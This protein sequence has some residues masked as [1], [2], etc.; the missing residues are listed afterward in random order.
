[1]SL[2]HIAMSVA[3][4]DQSRDFYI[5]A[6]SPLGYKV[7]MTQRDGEVTS[8]PAAKPREKTGPLHIAFGASNRAQVRKFHEAAI[9][10]GGKCNGPP[11]LRPQY[12]A[13]Y[14]AAFVLDPEGR[15]IEAICMKPGFLAEEWGLIGWGAAGLVL[16][17][18]GGGIAKWVGWI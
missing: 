8:T 13:T 17:A 6:L 18:M 15:N 5:A 16:S 10:A 3:N 12:F 4:I 9:A 1:M 11:G 14:Y 7:K 2:H